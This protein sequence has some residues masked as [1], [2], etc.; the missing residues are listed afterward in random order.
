MQETLEILATRMKLLGYTELTPIQ[1]IAIPKVL[2]G[3]NTLI[4]APTGFGKTEA[5]VIP[6]FTE[7][8]IERPEKISGIYV[9]PLRAL[10][11]DIEVRLTKIASAFGVS[12]G[13]RHGDST[14]RDR[15][16]IEKEPPDLLITTPETFEFLLINQK[17]REYLSNVRWLII[18]EVQEMLDDKRGYEMSIAV[19]RLKIRAKQKIQVIGISATI[20]E[21]EAAKHFLHPEGD[22]DIA[23]V[24]ISREMK[25]EVAIPNPGEEVD[26]VVESGLSPETYARVKY[27]SD[28]I[29]TRK[30][31]LLFTN[32]RETAEYL[33]NVLRN[34]FKLNVEVHHG[35]LSRD[36]R[37]SAEKE[38][39]AGKLDALVATSSLELGIDVGTINTV[40]QYSSPRQ[41]LRLIQRVGRS[42]HFFKK[43]PNGVVVPTSQVEDVVECI[44]ITDFAKEGKLEKPITEEDALDVVAHQIALMV[45]EGYSEPEKIYDIVRKSFYFR[46]LEYERFMNVVEFLKSAYIISEKNGKLGKSRRIWKYAFSVSMIPESSSNFLAIDMVSDQKIGT[47][48]KDFVSTLSE[49]DVIVLSGKLWRVISIENDKVF[50]ERTQT[51]SG[52]LPSWYGETIPVEIQVATEVYRRFIASSDIQDEKV[53]EEI[54]KMLAELRRRGFPSPAEDTAL[55]EV[56]KGGLVVINLPMGTR[57]NNTIG[58][59]ISLF[60]LNRTGG[61]VTYRSDAYHIA[62]ASPYLISKNDV[63]QAL[64]FLTQNSEEVLRGWL[65]KAIINSP[66]YKWKIVTEAIRFGAID[67]DANVKITKTMLDAYVNTI[68]GEEAVNELE[69]YSYDVNVF[70]EVKKW[71]FAVVETVDPSPL[72]KQFLEKIMVRDSGEPFMLEIFKRKLQQRSVKLLCSICYW[73]SVFKVKDVPEKCPKCGSVFLSLHEPE[74]TIDKKLLDKV[75]TNG[76][77]HKEER[78]KIEEIK[79]TSSLFSTYRK[80][81]AVAFVTP[82]V[83]PHNMGRMLSKLSQGEDAF[84]KTL[85]DAERNFIRNRKYWID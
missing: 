32:T 85:L 47:L 60:L 1:K 67:K 9:T 74:D 24:N 18:D 25:I 65:R 2:S 83:G 51:S 62:I 71:K 58:A 31:V 63:E 27:I 39:K 11:R 19:E 64:E 28:I 81:A 73:N 36:V 42:G 46:T 76:K 78:E 13:V 35:S 84:Y 52:H 6:V 61:R 72:S 38:F 17:L 44:V 77:L 82:G 56:L 45:M 50:L 59:L 70:T 49:D 37:V 26:K 8:L 80:L 69:K 79:I 10:N 14:E 68:I 29:R 4:V 7:I 21:I 30:P 34:L 20:G 23:L 54:N 33:S 5:A 66:Q 57:G 55:T 22:V 48:D 43:V 75:K 41:A 3:K 40:I 15:R 16:R 12:V 53:K